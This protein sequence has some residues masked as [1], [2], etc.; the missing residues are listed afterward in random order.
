MTDKAIKQQIDALK[1]VTAKALQS[2][3]ASTRLLDNLAKFSTLTKQTT[4]S[5]KRK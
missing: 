1:S 4:S 5:K 2:K 3:A